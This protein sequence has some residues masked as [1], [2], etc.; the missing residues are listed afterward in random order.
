MRRVLEYAKMFDLPVIAHC[1]DRNLTQRG[2]IN[3]GRISTLLGLRGMPSEAEEIMVARNIILARLTGGRLHIAHLSTRGA[4]ELVRQAK[5]EG[6]R[7]TAE[8]APHYFVLSEEEV[9]NFDPNTKINPPLR[10]KEDVKAIRKGLA[11]GVI[12]LIATDHA[13]HTEEEKN[14]EYALAPFGIIGLETAFPLTFTY[15][16]E[17][18]VLSLKEAVAKW[19]IAPARV[20]GLDRGTLSSGSVGDLVIIDPKKEKRVEKFYSKS[21]NSPF[22]G[23]KLRGFA[24]MTI[25]GGRIVMANGKIISS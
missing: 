22:L 24:E 25:V 14:K 4:M 8:T 10:S 18:K 2:V 15:L 6:L 7:I 17:E 19:T 5:K 3:E 1:E 23:R 12:D 13:P 21:K 20:A 16:V 11:E 9:V